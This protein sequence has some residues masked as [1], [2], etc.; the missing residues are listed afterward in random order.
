MSPGSSTESYPAFARIGLRKNP[1]KNLNQVTC[2]DR[3][4][5]LGHLVSRP[6]A[7]TITPQVRD[8]SP[9]VL[10]ADDCCCRVLVGRHEG[11][12]PLRRPR[13][14]WEKEI[15]MDLREVEN[16]ARNWINLAHDRDRWRAYLRV[17]S[18]GLKRAETSFYVAEVVLPECLPRPVTPVIL[19]MV[20]VSR[21]RRPFESPNALGQPPWISQSMVIGDPATELTP[22][23]T[24]WVAY[25]SDRLRGCSV[26][27]SCANVEFQKGDSL[28]LKS[29]SP[30][31]EESTGLFISVPGDASL[32]YRSSARVC[33]RNC[34]SIRRP[35]FECSGP[36]LEGPE[37]ECSGP[38]LEGPEFEYSG[39]PL[40]RLETLDCRPGAAG[41]GVKLTRK[42]SE[43]R[44]AA[45]G[46]EVASPIVLVSGFALAAPGEEQILQAIA[47]MK[48]EMKDEMNKHISEL[49]NDISEVKTEMKNDISGV[50]GDISGVKGDISGVKG[51]ISGV[52]DD[53]TTQIESVS[54]HVDGIVAIVKDEL[55]DDLDKLNQNFTTKR[56]SSSV[57]TGCRPF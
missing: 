48:A 39:L 8:A 27:M 13:R 50:K 30:Y 31:G 33:V 5:N 36:Q 2:P 14:R 4:S 21:L 43:K 54:A 24:G 22:L 51:D 37:F 6:D 34:V 44:L 56:D 11:K 3:D 38:Q 25:T 12:R 23:P 17:V 53:V 28:S 9:R 42:A 10:C 47:E 15:K 19:W 1:E 20:E 26:G 18:K 35:E 52:K 7:L 29:P 40:K 41:G 32:L 55:K 45:P 46:E 49:K 16:D 57:E